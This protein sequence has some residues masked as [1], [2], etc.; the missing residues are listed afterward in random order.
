MRVTNLVYTTRLSHTL[1]LP[2]L[3]KHGQYDP[4][5]FRG[6]IIRVGGTCLVF[7]NGQVVIVGVKTK[8]QAVQSVHCLVKLIHDAV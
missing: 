1:D 3:A 2:T 5:K 4:N 8:K 7:H 6:L